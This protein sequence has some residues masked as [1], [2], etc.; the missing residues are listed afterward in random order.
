[1][2]PSNTIVLVCLV[3]LAAIVVQAACPND[4]SGNGACQSDGKTC[5]CSEPYTGVDCSIYE[6]HLKDGT[7]VDADVGRKMWNYYDIAVAEGEASLTV[8]LVQTSSSGDCDVYIR[9]G[10]YP[11]KENYFTRDITSDASFS[12]D[13]DGPSEGTWYIGVYG[14]VSCSYTITVELA[15]SPCPNDC[16]GHGQCVQVDSDNYYCNCDN[17]YYGTECKTETTTLFLD[18]PHSTHVGV[19]SWDLYAYESTDPFSITVEEQDDD[20]DCDLY[21]RHNKIPTVYKFDARDTSMKKDMTLEVPDPEFGPYF[22]GVF[23]FRPCK[24]DIVVKSL[25]EQQE[26]PND[27]SHHGTCSKKYACKCDAEYTGAYCE[28]MLPSLD[29]GD[30][31]DGYVMEGVWNFYHI[32]ADSQN[33][34]IINIHEHGHADGEE[35]DVFVR[36]GAEP[37]FYE[38]D[39]ME[40]SSD[41]EDYYVVVEDPSDQTWFV[42]VHGYRGCEYS[43][44]VNVTS[45]VCPE[46]CGDHGT[47]TDGRC[48]CDDTYMGDDCETK[49]VQLTSAVDHDDSV[50][51]NEWA[52]FSI[53][54]KGEVLAVY[55]KEKSSIGF[56]ELYV[57]EGEYPTRR[58][59]DASDT[60]SNDVHR[61]YITDE[62]GFDVE[63]YAPT[64][65]IGV[66]GSSAGNESADKLD[67]T[68]VAWNP[69][70]DDDKR[71]MKLKLKRL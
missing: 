67:F 56:L 46:G 43:I 23:G 27:C 26:C 18:T 60:E 29:I 20:S 41:K 24:Y 55:L 68:V 9:K 44:F 45:D 61:V 63:D 52:Y 38:Y 71:M 31:I 40:T 35:C 42:G 62:D 70:L 12:V 21:V 5:E 22:I 3:S 13:I 65:Y 6:M 15:H 32:D 66:Y 64:F 48:L 57:S 58:T 51:R 10:D 17:N 1:M 36:A 34:L 59:N 28:T 30:E 50:A 33:N 16:N 49:V 14:F 47:C 69:D 11:S 54:T 37:T 19:S 53:E 7:T 8:N 2:K 25:E 4:C 39:Y